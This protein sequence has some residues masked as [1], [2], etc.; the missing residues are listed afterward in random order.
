MNNCHSIVEFIL[1]GKSRLPMYIGGRSIFQLK[2]FLDGW[3][4][5]SPD[6]IRDIEALQ[7]FQCWIEE[8]FNVR[9]NQSWAKIIL[10]YS[11]DECEALENFLKLFEDF[12]DAE[13]SK[14]D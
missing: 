5:G 2:A 6:K 11:N 10:F 1:S 7:D 8:K 3:I 9:S 12:V 4:F 13:N 14:C